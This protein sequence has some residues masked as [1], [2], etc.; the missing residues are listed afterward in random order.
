MRREQ[1]LAPERIDRHA[2]AAL[3]C[4][5]DVLVACGVVQF[6]GAG[7]DEDVII[8]KLAVIDLRPRNF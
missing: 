8:G 4:R 5:I 2:A 3:V 1:K 6:A 7:L